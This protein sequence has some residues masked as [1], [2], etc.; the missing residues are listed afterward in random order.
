MS[1]PLKTKI[2]IDALLGSVLG[3]LLNIPTLFLGWALRRDHRLEVQGDIVIIKLLG[4]GS[5][6]VAYPALLGIRKRY[7]SV[8]LKIITTPS[9]RPFAETLGLFD[10]IVVLDDQTFPRLCWSAVGAIATCFRADTIIDIEIYSYMSAIL[11]LLTCAR[12]RIGFFYNERGFR[13]FLNTHRIFYPAGSPLY[14][15]YDY[16]ATLIGA[17]IPSWG[18]CRDQFIATN[19]LVLSDSADRASQLAIGS[20][21]SPLSPERRLTPEQ[22]CRHIFEPSPLKDSS[23]F[24]L[25]TQ[26]DRPDTEALTALVKT[27]SP[28]VWRGEVHNLCGELSLQ[29]SLQILASCGTFWGI[30]SSLFHYARLLGLS[31]KAFFGPT[32]P[33]QL[34]PCP[35]IKEEIFYRPPICSPCVHMVSEPPCHG[36]NRCIKQ[37]FDPP[38]EGPLPETESC[39]APTLTTPNLWQWF[40]Q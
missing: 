7:P 19:H 9:V 18:D 3:F 30:E 2:Q 4:G 23:V 17:T 1:I 8:R 28:H 31:C 36:D 24:F 29:E 16:M 13:Q 40:K 38:K 6:V 14:R 10:Q 34:R 21:C 32:H 5:L 27:P 11:S 35:T 12:N 25:G 22:W 39:W 33:R 37:L 20:G 15:H 26:E